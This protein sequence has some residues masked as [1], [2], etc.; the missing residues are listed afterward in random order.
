[1]KRNHGQNVGP[2]KCTGCHV[3]TNSTIGKRHRKCKAAKPGVW[4]HPPEPEKQK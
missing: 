2:A 1:V 4:Q 3:E